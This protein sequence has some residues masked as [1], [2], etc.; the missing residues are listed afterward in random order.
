MTHYISTVDTAKHIRKALKLNFPNTKFSV[1]SDIYSGGSSINVSW[2]D[3]EFEKEVAKVVKFYEGASFD[4]QIDLKSY[5]TTTFAVEGQPTEVHFGADYVFTHRDV[6]PEY[7][8]QL[9]EKFEEISGE[10]YEDEKSYPSEKF[11]FVRG[12]P[13]AYG[14]QIIHKMSYEFAPKQLVS[15]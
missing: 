15:A 5:H 14:C 7:K 3:G 4:G 2:T 8:A 1:R 12:V 10:K 11:D 6:S 9:I 13:T